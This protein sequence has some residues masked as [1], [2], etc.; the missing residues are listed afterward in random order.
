MYC[1]LRTGLKIRLNFATIYNRSEIRW[2]NLSIN[3]NKEENNS[4]LQGKTE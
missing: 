1:S 4:S 2:P 3:E